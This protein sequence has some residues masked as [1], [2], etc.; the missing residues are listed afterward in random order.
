[1]TSAHKLVIVGAGG[2]A[3]EVL[4]LVRELRRDPFHAQVMPDPIGIIDSAAGQP[5]M[6]LPILGDDN[7]AFKHLDR[8]RV[9]FVCAI[10]NPA[11]RGKVCE[12]FEAN[13]YI[14]LTLIHPS[15]RMSE[16]VNIGRGAI[17]CAGAVLTTHIALGAYVIVNLNAT[18]GHDVV[19]GDMV[20]I[21]PGVNISGNVKIGDGVEVG[22]GAVIL[23]GVTVGKGAV[24]GA[25]AVVIEDVPAGST[26]VGNPAKPIK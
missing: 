8:G 10:G 18:I 2:F 16:E 21:N 13:G 17:L 14:A 3:R 6:G 24:I 22:T 25:G 11:A 5:V 7:W 1:M 20:T 26:V 9:S 15:V 4:W 23:P 19:I 12:R